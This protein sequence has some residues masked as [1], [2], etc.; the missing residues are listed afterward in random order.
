MLDEHYNEIQRM[1]SVVQL[2]PGGRRSCVGCHERADRVPSGRFAGPVKALKRSPSTPS[3][4]PGEAEARRLFDYERDIQ[5][6]WE[7]RCVGCHN[8][9]EAAKGKLDLTGTRT[10]LYCASYENLMGLEAD[11][12][13]RSRYSLVGRQVN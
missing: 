10:A 7:R 12:S 5:P 3:R 8:D 4:Q 11:K 9:T 6:I 1:C 13:K 2:Q